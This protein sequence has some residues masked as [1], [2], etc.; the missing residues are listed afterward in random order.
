[1]FVLKL[2]CHALFPEYLTLSDFAVFTHM[3]KEIVKGKICRRIFKS[4]L[5]SK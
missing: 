2:A 5:L 1:M 3:L 4:S